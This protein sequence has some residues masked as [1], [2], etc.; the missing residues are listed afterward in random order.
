MES[1][2]VKLAAIIGVS[3]LLVIAAAWAVFKWGI[4][5]SITILENAVTKKELNDI[6]LGSGFVTQA[7]L[8]EALSS[9]VTTDKLTIAQYEI[10][11]KFNDALTQTRHDIRNEL[12]AGLAKVEDKLD[13]ITF[14]MDARVQII[15][16]ATEKQIS[17]ML[18]TI[19]QLI[20]EQR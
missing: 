1:E 11:T 18:T 17:G 14:E 7:D 10:Q 9:L 12:M 15:T 19:A 8:K 3:L 5:K 6:L 4:S 20:K 13:K 16:N 2:I